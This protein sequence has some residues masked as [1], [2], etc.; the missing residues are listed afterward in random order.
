M[1]DMPTAESLALTFCLN[2]YIQPSAGIAPKVESKI[3]A[4]PIKIKAPKVEAAPPANNNPPPPSMN[5]PN[6]GS[7]DAKTYIKRRASA[8]NRE[9][10]I[11]ALAAYVGYDPTKPFGLQDS[12]AF[13]Q[14]KLTLRP[15]AKLAAPFSRGSIATVQ[16]FVAGQP[17]HAERA[18]QNLLARERLAANTML[19][20]EKA[21]R[22]AKTETDR[23][24]Y[25]GLALVER[26]RLVQIRK[27]LR[28]CKW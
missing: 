13:D 3:D 16:G 19:D 17:D 23:T 24:L 12:A 28:N 21:A 20:H 14:A 26:E 7:I 25:A 11:A 4:K 8:K 2:T 5:L 18:Y 22:D 1:S 27:D 6:A 15:V 10:C 9:E